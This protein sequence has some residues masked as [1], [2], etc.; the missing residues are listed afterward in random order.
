MA[1]EPDNLML[2]LLRDIRDTQDKHSTLLADHS[3]QFREIRREMHERQES[4]ATAMGFAGH[5]NI[6]TESLQKQI[7]A[8]V[9]R[10]DRLERQH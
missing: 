7:D 3:R 8:L 10:L 2:R 1:E 6:R 5:A 9:E 4:T